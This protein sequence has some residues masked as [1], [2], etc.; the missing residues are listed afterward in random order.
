MFNCCSSGGVVFA[1][2]LERKSSLWGQTGTG[3]KTLFP[4]W[5]SPSNHLICPDCPLSGQAVNSEI[6]DSVCV[7]G[8]G[9]DGGGGVGVGVRI[10]GAEN[11]IVMFKV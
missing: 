1:C 5:S 8:G 7:W 11:L 2:A 10:A 6:I 9:E 3:R 4:L